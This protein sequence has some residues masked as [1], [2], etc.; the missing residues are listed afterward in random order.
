[1]VLALS[2][3]RIGTTPDHAGVFLMPDASSK[4]VGE[5]EIPPISMA[6]LREKH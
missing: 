2:T 1:V 3:V 4:E 5:K 6:E